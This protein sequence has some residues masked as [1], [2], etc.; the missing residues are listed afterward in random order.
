MFPDGMVFIGGIA[1]YLHTV[2]SLSFLGITPES[3]HNADMYIGLSDLADLR[4]IECLTPNRRLSKHQFIKGGFD[5]DVYVERNNGLIVPYSHLS[6]ESILVG[7]I[8]VANPGHLLPL[9]LEACISRSGTEKGEKD[10]RDVVKIVRMCG[11]YECALAADFL[12]EEHLDMLRRI[13]KS[14]AFIQIAE[15]NAM[16]ASVARKDFSASMGVI[17]ATVLARLSA[18]KG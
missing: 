5:F 9:K 7:G 15:G 17:D 14:S 11:D 2:N 3:S 10:M 16:K 18:P 12:T 8:R 13:E 6:A 4:E 1:V